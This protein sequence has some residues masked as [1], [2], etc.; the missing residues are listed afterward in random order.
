MHDP[1][2]PEPLNRDATGTTP[3]KCAESGLV[4]IGSKQVFDQLQETRSDCK[5]CSSL[6][7]DDA[8]PNTCIYR[9]EDSCCIQTVCLPN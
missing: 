4:R 5:N 2:S 6:D 7:W 3:D 8:C 9:T 1:S